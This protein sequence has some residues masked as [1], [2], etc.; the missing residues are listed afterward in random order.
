MSNK[1]PILC[2]AALLALPLAL[3][4]CAKPVGQGQSASQHRPVY[5]PLIHS[6]SLNPSLALAQQVPT[7][8]DGMTMEAAKVRI[9]YGSKVSAERR[10]ELAQ[11]LRQYGV[12]ATA[13]QWLPW[14]DA[15][16]GEFLRLSI[17][18]NTAHA[19]NCLTPVSRWN[20]ETEGKWFSDTAFSTQHGCSVNANLAAQMVKPLELDT[21]A[22]LDTPNA[23]RAVGAVEA[24]QGGKVRQ[25]N[26]QSME[27]GGSSSPM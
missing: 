5:Q 24:Y 22:T 16:Q 4:A 25:F 20:A 26:E 3:I 21:A 23:V 6:V 19:P 14:H 10:A 12:S 8:L 27:A 1:Y 11:L 17:S 9:D 15:E 7:Q 18:R 13:Q 2:R